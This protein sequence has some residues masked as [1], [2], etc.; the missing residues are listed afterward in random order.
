MIDLKNTRR[1]KTNAGTALRIIPDIIP[2]LLLSKLNNVFFCVSIVE[3]VTNLA[4][5][6][7]RYKLRNSISNLILFRK[8]KMFLY[9]I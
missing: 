6:Y 9:Q 1:K 5:Y 4:T 7:C 2:K 3:M 8:A